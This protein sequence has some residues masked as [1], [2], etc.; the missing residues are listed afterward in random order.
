VTVALFVALSLVVELLDGVTDRLAL[1]DEL[2]EAVT[3]AVGVSDGVKRL[4]TTG[5][6]LVDGLLLN[7][8]VLLTVGVTD[9]V[10]L[11]D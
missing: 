10:I 8:G 5:N 9:R 11:A 7:S 1:I 4:L 2:I 3:D 6:E